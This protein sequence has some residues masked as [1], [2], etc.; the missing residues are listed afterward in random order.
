MKNADAYVSATNVATSAAVNQTNT[1][2][3]VGALIVSLAIIS[4]KK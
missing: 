2:I 1:Y 3:L 4:M